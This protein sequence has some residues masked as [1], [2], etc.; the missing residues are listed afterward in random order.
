MKVHRK[1]HLPK[2]VSQLSRD[3]SGEGTRLYTPKCV[4]ILSHW[5]FFNTNIKVLKQFLR[6]S[7]STCPIP[8]ER[9]IANFICDVPLPP[10]GTMQVQHTIADE[11][12]FISRYFDRYYIIYI[13]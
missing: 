11:T 13:T 6:L 10:R 4:C 2:W 12:I 5:P 1:L 9:Y 3:D 8:L 7:R